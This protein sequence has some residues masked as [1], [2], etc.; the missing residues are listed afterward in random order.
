MEGGMAYPAHLRK[1]AGGSNGSAAPALVPEP[2][3][4][5]GRP[6][7]QLP[8][9]DKQTVSPE[10]EPI[11]PRI[12]GVVIDRRRLQEDERGDLMEIYN[13]AWGIHGEPLVYAYLVG[14][15]PRRVKG[16]VVHRL[17]DDRLFFLRGVIRVALFDD[18]PESPTFRMLNV[19]MMTEKSRGLVIVPKGV[20]HA[21][22]NI[23]N[24]DASF[25]NLPTK[26][27]D[28]LHPDKYRLPLRNA[29]IPFCF[30]ET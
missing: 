2:L 15:R 19:F 25:L 14:I 18:R 28:H 8:V 4:R 22:K 17:Q 23:G 20:F 5:A 13:P 27:Y 11:A 7:R 9:K 12:A 26:P 24:R 21:L 6:N 1:S 29:R 3:P 10:G 30:E 16:W